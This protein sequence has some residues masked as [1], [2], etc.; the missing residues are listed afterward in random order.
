M[1][2]IYRLVLPDPCLDRNPG[3][4]TEARGFCDRPVHHQVMPHLRHLFVARSWSQPISIRQHQTR[5]GMEAG[6]QAAHTCL[7]S[8]TAIT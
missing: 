6:G 4:E 5:A 2:M 8:H 3:A 7:E 1:P